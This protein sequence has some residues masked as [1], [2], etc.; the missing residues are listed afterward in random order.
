MDRRIFLKGA[1]ATGAL[2]VSGLDLQFARAARMSSLTDK[3]VRPTDALSKPSQPEQSLADQLINYARSLGASY[4]DV[5]IVRYLS[6]SVHA[7]DN[8]V[9][10]ISDSESYGVGIRVIKDGTWGFTATRN[11]N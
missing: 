7:R 3:S 4:C 9:T 5:R 8:I 11:V 2:A 1:L 6:Q 10:G